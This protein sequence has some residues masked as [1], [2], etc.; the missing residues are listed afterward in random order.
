MAQYTARISIL[1][2]VMLGDQFSLGGRTVVYWPAA[3]KV[4]GADRYNAQ[5]WVLSAGLSAQVLTLSPLG[6]S[7]TGGLLFFIADNPV[8]LRFNAGSDVTF[9][10]AVRQLTM[11]AHISNLFV[12]T[13]AATVIH[14]ELV[15][16]SAATLTATLPLP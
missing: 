1:F 2:E 6:V 5:T 8:D 14:L 3:M 12:T 13:S 4:T 11:G 9:L 10:S 15:G 7:A 16:G